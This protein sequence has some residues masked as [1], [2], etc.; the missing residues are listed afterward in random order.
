ML[1]RFHGRSTRESWVLDKFHT[2][3]MA[4]KV[5]VTCQNLDR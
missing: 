4:V 2:K 1:G 3:L 5:R